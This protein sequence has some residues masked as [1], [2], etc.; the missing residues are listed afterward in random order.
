MLH[1]QTLITLEPNAFSGL[2]TDEINTLVFIFKPNSSENYKYAAQNFIITEDKSAI[3][4]NEEAM[5]A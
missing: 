4:P 1:G 5:Q 3:E 2:K